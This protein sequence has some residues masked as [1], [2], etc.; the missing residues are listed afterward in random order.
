M[1][2]RGDALLA[3]A[4]EV[5]SSYIVKDKGKR[6]NFEADPTL[7]VAEEAASSGRDKRGNNGPLSCSTNLNIDL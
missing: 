1:I 2:G 4:E 6:I 5:V 7:V 3:V